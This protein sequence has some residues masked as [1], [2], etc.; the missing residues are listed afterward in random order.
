MDLIDQDG[1]VHRPDLLA[2][3]PAGTLVVDYKTGQED[4]A[5]H[6]QVRRYLRLAGALPQG[7]GR[8]ARGLVVYLDL[9]CVRHVCAGEDAAMQGM[10]PGGTP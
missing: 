3:T 9:Q 2:F 5:H 4:Q 6:D 10:S 1:R 7:R 8:E